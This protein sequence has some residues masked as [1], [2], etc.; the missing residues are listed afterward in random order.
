M[1]TGSV[2][3]PDPGSGGFFTHGSGIR[4]SDEHLKSFFRELGNSF[5]DFEFK[6]PTIL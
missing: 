5:S 1:V 4:I 2:A 6:K 3:D